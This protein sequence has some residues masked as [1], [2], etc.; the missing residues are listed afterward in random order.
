MTEPTQPEGQPA[1]P[2]PDLGFFAGPATGARAQFGGGSFGGPAPGVQFGA[3]PAANQ[4][5]T[6]PAAN[7][8]GTAP[9]TSQFGTPP[10]AGYVAPSPERKPAGG[11]FGKPSGVWGVVCMAIV[12]LAAAGFGFNRLV[13]L[14]DLFKGDLEPPATLAGIPRL[15]GPE[16]ERAEESAAKSLEDENSGDAAAASYVSDVATYGLAAQRVR[17][18]IDRELADVGVGGQGQSYGDNTCAT[19]DAATVCIRTS[20]SLTVLVVGSTGPDQV[21]AAL[22]EAWD[23]L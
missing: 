11:F 23:A 13:F 16:A 4:F 18:D 20:R 17:V 2:I 12:L 1:R 10:P 6:A 22:D 3:A 15:T 7:Q 19:V 8:F 21:S 5:G 9:V 14:S